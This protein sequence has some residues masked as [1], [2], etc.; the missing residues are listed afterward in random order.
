M[1]HA[2]DSVVVHVRQWG[3]GKETGANV[4]TT[5]GKCSPFATERWSIAGI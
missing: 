2:G 5:L 3:H 1:V 4:E